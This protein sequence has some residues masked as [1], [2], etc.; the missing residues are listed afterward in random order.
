VSENI[1][2]KIRSLVLTIKFN[3]YMVIADA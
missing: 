3:I 1:N 2:D